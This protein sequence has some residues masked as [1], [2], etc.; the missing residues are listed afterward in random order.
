MH[1]MTKNIF[2]CNSDTR[3]N[4]YMNWRTDHIDQAYN[5]YVLASDYADGAETLIK[6]ILYDNLDKK[7]DAL[8]MPILYSIDQSIELYM[9]SVIRELEESMGTVSNYKIHDIDNLKSIMMACIKKRLNKTKG[10]EKH[11]Q[12]VTSFIDELYQKIKVTDSEGQTCTNIDF[13]RYPITAEGIPH[14]YVEAS[15]NIVIDVENLGMRFSEIRNSLESLY[16]MFAP[17]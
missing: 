6:C 14:F 5:L 11:L 10:L 16:L 12:P 9:K 2:S 1:T 4:A 8:I 15:D 7:A 13:A 3:K 17:E